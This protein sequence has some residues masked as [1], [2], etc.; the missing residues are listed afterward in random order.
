MPLLTKWEW[1]VTGTINENVRSGNGWMTIRS[2]LCFAQSSMPMLYDLLHA[3]TKLLPAY[4][5]PFLTQRQDPNARVVPGHFQA[6]NA[7]LIHVICGT[8]QRSTMMNADAQ[9]AECYIVPSLIPHHWVGASRRGPISSSLSR[10]R[11]FYLCSTV[12]GVRTSTNRR[13]PPNV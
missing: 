5:P 10:L 1:R 9:N 11:S 7:V 4:F 2:L 6:N 8:M 13:R 12:S 3:I